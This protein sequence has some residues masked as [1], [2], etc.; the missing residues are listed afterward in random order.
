M[1]R[2]LSRVWK[3]FMYSSYHQYAG[4]IKKIRIKGPDGLPE[5][6]DPDDPDH[7]QEGDSAAVLPELEPAQAAVGMADLEPA[8][9]AVGVADLEPAQSDEPQESVRTA[10]AESL[11]ERQNPGKT[12]H[13]GSKTPGADKEEEED[14]DGDSADVRMRTHDLRVDADVNKATGEDGMSGRNGSPAGDAA[15]Q[16]R[17]SILQQV[18]ELVSK[19]GASHLDLPSA[20]TTTASPPRHSCL[21]ELTSVDR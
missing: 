15:P 16:D 1:Q 6:H 13:A 19:G 18:I 10:R 17:T 14:E 3:R 5:G 7:E 2:A 8:Q 4:V 11:G 20:L 9:A 12:V 21:E